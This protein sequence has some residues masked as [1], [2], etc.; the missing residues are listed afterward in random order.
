MGSGRQRMLSVLLPLIVSSGQCL[1]VA[2]RSGEE[3][4][5]DIIKFTSQNPYILRKYEAALG[6]YN[7]VAGVEVGGRA[8]WLHNNENYFLYFSNASAMWAV[9]EVL[10]GDEAT[11]ENL[12]D[13]DMCP[14]QVSD[15]CE[16]C[17]MRPRL[18][19]TLG[20]EI[21]KVERCY[22]YESLHVADSHVNVIPIQKFL[23][24]LSIPPPNNG[25]NAV[26]WISLVLV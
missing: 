21:M 25:K 6:L 4:G 10:G 3:C 1:E 2:P 13:T 15:H 23:F 20:S 12:G 7:R 24:A 11:I 16:R 5:C 8:V 18:I 19:F 17:L 14:D 26:Q 22:C 9:G